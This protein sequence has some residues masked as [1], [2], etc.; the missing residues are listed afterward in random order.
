MTTGIRPGS[1]Y[2]RILQLLD[3]ERSVILNGPLAGL[4]ELV[5]RR[6]VVLA[7]ILAQDTDAPEEFLA[8]VK[9]KAERNSRLILASLAGI[10]AADAEIARIRDARD[11]LRTYTAAG[12]SVERRNAA[13]TREK[14]A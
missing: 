9:I 4:K 10:K 14:R 3:L 7:E 13:V 6:E 1:R 5:E 8:A 11:Q 12:T 2:D